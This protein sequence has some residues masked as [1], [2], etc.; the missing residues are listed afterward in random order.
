MIGKSENVQRRVQEE[1]VLTLEL[2]RLKKIMV[3]VVKE[4]QVCKKHVIPKS[5]HV[6]ILHYILMTLDGH[7]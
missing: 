3:E 7:I 1:R 6:G 5:V 4:K 2:K